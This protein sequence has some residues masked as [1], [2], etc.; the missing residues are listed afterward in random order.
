MT[1]HELSALRGHLCVLLG[2]QDE[3]EAVG[4]PAA[5]RALNREAIAEARRRLEYLG[6]ESG[7]LADAT[8]ARSS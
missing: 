2:I 7:D 4:A 5:R 8:S 1:E 6:G 3:L